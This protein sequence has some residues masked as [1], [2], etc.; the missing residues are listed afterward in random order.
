MKNCTLCLIKMLSKRLSKYV[1]CL[2]AV[3]LCI[4][5][6]FAYP[7]ISGYEHHTSRS[8]FT[9]QV[10]GASWFFSSSQVHL[11]SLLEVVV[12]QCGAS[13]PNRG[14]MFTKAIRSQP[15]SLPT[16]RRSQLCSHDRCATRLAAADSCASTCPKQGGC[17]CQG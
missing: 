1:H 7:Q 10:T 6:L 3:W 8:W 11:S 14:S 17:R 12:F 16:P 5:C 9:G 15:S 13:S 2:S 4:F